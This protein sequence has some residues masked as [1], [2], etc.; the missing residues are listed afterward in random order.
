MDFKGAAKDMEGDWKKY[1]E[2]GSEC[3]SQANQLGRDHAIFYDKQ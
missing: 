1:T 2:E 3:P